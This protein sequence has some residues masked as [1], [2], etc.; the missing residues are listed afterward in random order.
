[1]HG[2]DEMMLRDFCERAME[3]CRAKPNESGSCPP[4]EIVR[5]G[6]VNLKE[7]RKEGHVGDHTGF[8]YSLEG[9]YPVFHVE[10]VTRRKEP[11]LLDDSGGTA[12][13]RKI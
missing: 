5:E 13:A 6:Y 4:R 7:M 12:A 1:M 3:C 11:T 2:P 10:C 9:E 8:L